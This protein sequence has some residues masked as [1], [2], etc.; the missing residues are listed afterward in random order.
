MK[1]SA[2]NQ[3][4]FARLGEEKLLWE[5]RDVLL[6]LLGVVIDFRNAEGES[7]RLASL[8]H[9][10][11]Y[12][13]LIRNTAVGLE[14]C[15]KCAA[16]QVARAVEKRECHCYCCHAG[17]MELTLPLYD[18]FGGFIGCMNSGQFLVEGELE[19]G[20]GELRE[21]ARRCGLDP[22]PVIALYHASPRLKREQMAGV[23]DYLALIGRLVTRTHDRLTF[24]EKVNAP[25][26]VELIRRY[27]EE[28][29]M[30]PMTVGSAAQRFSMSDGHFLHFCRRNLGMSFMSYV[31][32]FRVSKACEML[33]ETK[34]SISE[35]ARLCGFGGPTQFNRGFRADTGISPRAYRKKSLPGAAG[36]GGEP[37]ALRGFRKPSR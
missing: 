36:G 23:A 15:R 37:G 33:A 32:S 9:F 4:V 19:F 14:A 16:D 22:A 10:N 35:V 5:Y 25:D 34:L 13:V 29:Y 3:R 30:H 18:N 24:M 31:R 17:L 2:L 12:C 26:R 28:N 1:F 11:P 8:Q 7:L 6:R 21:V 20:E 27:V